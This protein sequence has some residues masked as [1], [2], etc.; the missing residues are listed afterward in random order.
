MSARSCPNW[1]VRPATRT[2]GVITVGA[3]DAGDNAAGYSNYGSSVNIWAPG[4]NIPVVPDRDNPN[5]SQQSGTSLASPIVAGVAAMMRAVNPA[6]DSETVRQILWDTGWPGTGRVTRGLD[7]FSGLPAPT[8]WRG[9]RESR[10]VDQGRPSRERFEKEVVM[11]GGRRKHGS[12][13][14]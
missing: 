8:S 4:N 11:A 3:L 9:R 1:N 10:E 7:A 14:G 5:G 6:L 13:L 2:P 12:C